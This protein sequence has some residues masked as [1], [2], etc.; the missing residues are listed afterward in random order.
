VR[1]AARVGQTLGLEV[2]GVED[3]YR[4]LVEGR[5]QPL[6]LRVLDEAARRG[7]TVLGTA[8][9]ARFFTPE[10]RMAAAESMKAFEGLL[11]IGGNG[12][13]TGAHLLAKEHGVKV[14]G[15]PASI[16]N[17]IGCSATAIGVDT[18]LNTIVEACDRFSDTARSHR[19]AFV[20]E[21]MGRQSG[22]L[23]MASAVAAGAD[24]VLFREQGRSETELVGAVA[25]VIRKAFA[26]QNKRRVLII[27]AEGVEVPCTRLVRNVEEQVRDALNGAEL[28]AVVLGHVVRGGA[29]SFQDR[30]VAGRLGLAAVEALLSGGSDEMV[31]W[32]SSQGGAATGDPMVHRHSLERVLEQTRSLLDGSSPVTRARVEMMQKAEGVLPL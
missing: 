10:G 15:L 17:D 19:R 13:L 23:A 29:P 25:Q 1:A 12:S 28:R 9:C 31:G 16:D 6:D 3:G 24:A 2:V 32:G 4:G 30:M 18:A 27:K 21:E 11:V 20:V 8:R 14:I 26:E 22:Y 7:G 5:L